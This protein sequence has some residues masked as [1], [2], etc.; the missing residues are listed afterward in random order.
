MSASRGETR[1]QRRQ[2]VTQRN[3]RDVDR[4]EID[5]VRH[6]GCR[7]RPGVHAFA[8]DDA[9]IGA[10][11]PIELAVADVERDH[12][13]RAAL[14]QDVGEAAGRRA[15]VERAASA[16][17]NGEDV[18]G[19]RE[20]DA[21]AADVR[22]IGSD[23]R[24][25]GARRHGGAGLRH[26]LAVDG[27]LAGE[28]Q[29][30]RPFARRRRG[31]V[32]RSGRRVAVSCQACDWI[33]GPAEPD[34]AIIRTGLESALTRQFLRVSTQSAI[35]S[36]Q[37]S[38]SCASTRTACARS[39]Q[40]GGHRARAVPVRRATGRSACR[41]PHPCR[42]S[43]RARS[44][45]LRRPGCRPRSERRARSQCP[46]RATA[47]TSVASAPAM[48]APLTADARISAP[49]FCR[50]IARRPSASSVSA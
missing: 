2:D 16:D 24:D 28:D 32:R 23:Q 14:Q 39:A 6:V 9:R 15:D 7:Q 35:A 40:L 3:E 5:R 1:R 30:A 20:L 48:I 27:D 44:R 8:D 47:S 36:S 25:V 17:G 12:V 11:L 50:C 10:Q 18:E 22:M 31:R 46:T 26:D 21:A 13:A 38:V 4:H 33:D 34:T 49:V 42:R 19:V 37:P 43:C 45:C 41:R 29:R